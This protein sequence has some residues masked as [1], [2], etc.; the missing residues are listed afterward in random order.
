[1]STAS[2]SLLS[3]TL[4]VNSNV[5]L[6]VKFPIV[7][8]STERFRHERRFDTNNHVPLINDI[9]MNEVAIKVNI[10]TPS[11]EYTLL[12]D[13]G[14]SDIWV[15]SFTC[16]PETG[17][18]EFLHRYDPK[19]SSTYH[20]FND[21]QTIHLNYTIGRAE[22]EY[23]EDLLSLQGLTILHQVMGMMNKI[24]GPISD[25]MKT[26]DRNH[27]STI[28]M[29]GIFGAGFSSGTMRAINDNLPYEPFIP[30]LY[31]SGKIPGPLFSVLLPPHSAEEGSIVLGGIHDFVKTI[32]YTSVVGH[33][34]ENGDK[35][36]TH[37]LVE[38]KAYE[39][40]TSITNN[41][42][43]YSTNHAPDMFKVDCH[44]FES[45]NRVNF[46]FPSSFDRQEKEI[47]VPIAIKDLI[48]KRESD[49]QCFLLILPSPDNRNFI[50]GNMFLRHFV[51][52]F[53][54]KKI[55]HELD[56]LL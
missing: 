49:H 54:F 50:L 28:I 7:K 14:S 42:Y 25:Q 38:M 56:F 19:N 3:N 22:G 17:C 21:T 34:L 9:F 41:T 33:S 4:F 12:F 11:Q 24:E 37:W 13:T 45:P 18:P 31:K 51:T 55:N 32:L 29:D 47:K 23:F 10:G 46:Y 2:S 43:Y 48:A 5:V 16:S 53:D 1:M 30:A 39:L 15:P 20:A 8:I 26:K 6:P 35:Q 44:L 40:A 27:S 52:V 36:Y